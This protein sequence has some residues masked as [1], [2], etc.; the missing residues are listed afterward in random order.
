MKRSFVR[1]MSGLLVIAMLMAL[2]VVSMADSVG[3]DNT[4]SVTTDGVMTSV[5]LRCNHTHATV[6]DVAS[7]L[8]LVTEKAATCTEPAYKE[9][10]CDFYDD[11][12]YTVREYT[13]AMLGHDYSKRETYAESGEGSDDYYLA[14]SRSGCTAKYLVTAFDGTNQHKHE[15]S[16]PVADLTLV[17]S[18][19]TAGCAGQV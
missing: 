11:C 15:V 1:I 8:K 7:T 2:P 14:C 12:G 17:D 9:Y 19:T 3:S 5:K 10:K 18:V 16:D 13:G 6:G 4:I